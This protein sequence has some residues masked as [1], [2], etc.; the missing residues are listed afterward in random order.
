VIVVF[1]S[2]NL[3]LV[4]RVARLPRPGETLAALGFDTSP[5]GKGANQ[6]LAARRAGAE[7]A[8][9]GAVGRDAFATAALALLDAEGVDLRGVQSTDAP[10]GVALIHVDDAGE[11]AITVVAGANARAR[12][13]D[14][15][16]SALG[17]H[18]T[19]VLQFETPHAQ[20]LALAR[21]A[22]A[23]GAR[24]VLN[25]A[26]A[27]PLD[28]GWL[29]VLDVLIANQ[30][31][32]VEI[33]RPLGLP[34][35]PRAFAGA[36]AT[37]HPL[38]VVVTL[39]REGAFAVRGRTT[40]AA[41]ALAVEARDTVGAGDTFAGALAAGLDR[42]DAL[43]DALA[44]GTAAGSLACTRPGAQAGI[45]SAAEID[46]VAATLRGRVATDPV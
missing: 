28:E 34:G 36:L 31:E 8:L 38:T 25:S 45:P 20:S 5:G 27:A 46:R 15:P 2:I 19:L 29:G 10:T 33:A 37:R 11:N 14:V 40:H 30:T 21:R 7:V 43:P 26:P 42:G 39:G 12:A 24:V 22:R 4:A 41:P 6:A 32:A 13:Q 44:Y 9:H 16:D 35:E 23:R 18:T 1:G 3:D 17:T